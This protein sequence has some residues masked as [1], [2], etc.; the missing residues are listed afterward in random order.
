MPSLVGQ[1]GLLALDR[2]Q[3]GRLYRVLSLAHSVESSVSSV[4]QSWS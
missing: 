3:H 1:P 2:L 4:Q